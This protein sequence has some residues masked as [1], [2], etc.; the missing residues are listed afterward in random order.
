MRFLWHYVLPVLTLFKSNVNTPAK[1]GKRL[2]QLAVGSQ[3]SATGKYYS[4]GHEASSSELSFDKANALDL[5]N[6]SAEMTQ[7]PRELLIASDS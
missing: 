7:L 1:S 6:S 3:G 2:A 4:D 5:W